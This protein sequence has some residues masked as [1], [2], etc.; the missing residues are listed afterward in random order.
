MSKAAHF[1]IDRDEI[2]REREK[3]LNSVIIHNCKYGYTI[4]VNNRVINVLYEEYKRRN[5]IY[6]APSDQQRLT[7]EKRLKKYLCVKYREMYHYE[8]ISPVLSGSWQEQ[9]LEECV[10]CLDVAAAIHDL[11]GDEGGTYG[12]KL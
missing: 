5:K 2:R 11:Y 3:R 9:Q 1:E 6:G 8:L 10:R 7:W 12:K 4:N